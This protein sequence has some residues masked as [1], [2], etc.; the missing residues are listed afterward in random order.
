M[1]K[2]ILSI[3][4]LAAY[5]S[6]F[7]QSESAKKIGWFITPEIGGMFL[8][9]HI[10]RT[11]G[12]SVGVELWQKRI[13]VGFHTYGRSGPI[14]PKTFTIQAANNQMYKGNTTLHLKA[15]H[16]AF[17]LLVAPTFKINR[18]RVDVPLNIGGIGAGF[19]LFD[20][21]RITPDG[22]RVSEWENQLMGGEDASFV[23]WMEFGVRGFVPLKTEGLSLGMGLHYT[24]TQGWQTYYDPSGNFYNNKLRFSLFF[25]FSGT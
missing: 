24:I 9:D 3:L 23:T 8:D 19:Y 21:D 15:D 25:N 10:G 20:D 7:S 11:V 1:K 6:T 13:K 16:T 22:R 14:N 18:W 4:L 17:G 12:G 5:N 2:L